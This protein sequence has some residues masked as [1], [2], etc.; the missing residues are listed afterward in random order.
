[1]T[2]YYVGSGGNDANS[3]LTWA[4][5][6][7]TLNGAEDVPVAAGD[8]VYV[9]PGTYRETLTVDVSGTAG[10]PITYIGDYTG[11]NTDGIGGV[12]RITGSN[13]DQT[14]ARA[15]CITA[16]TQNYR[17]FTGFSLDTTSS[18]LISATGGPTNW[19]IDKNYLASNPVTPILIDGA[20]Q[21]TNTIQ[22][23]VFLASKDRS[24]RFNHSALVDNTSHLVQNCLFV[25]AGSV[26]GISSDK[27]GG[28][29]VKNCTFLGQ[30]TGAVR[31]VTAITVGQ[32]ITVN[33]CIF[34]GCQT[35][36]Q[37][38]V[39]GEVVEN[40]NTFYANATDRTNT[41]TGANSV[42]YP[43]L[44]DARWAFQLLYAQN[45]Y[46]QVISLFDLASFSQLVNL[47][48]TSPTTTDLRG[49]AIL[50]AQREWGALEY[51]SVLKKMGQ[52]LRPY[53]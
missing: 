42:T 12:V 27:I 18:Y 20:G 10:N 32:T 33:N 5:R 9:G 16:S 29:T 19:I 49:Q 1:M 51:N 36:L 3:G 40:Y 46:A 35:A 17:T 21:S 28:I 22:N 34:V 13:N 14:A 23:C 30:G 4:L 11:V 53:G 43:P 37:G 26:V 44:F 52:I 38:T 15:N 25:G 7:L 2:T 41:N 31:V 39:A 47:A 6:K 48:G 24:L 45:P 8:T 50:G